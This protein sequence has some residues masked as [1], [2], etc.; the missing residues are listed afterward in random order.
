[1]KHTIALVM[2]L[3]SSICNIRHRSIGSYLDYAVG[4]SEGW[5]PVVVALTHSV[6]TFGVK[7]TVGG[8]LIPSQSR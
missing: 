3:T 6:T 5:R 8:V 2:A 4:G 7:I 1:V